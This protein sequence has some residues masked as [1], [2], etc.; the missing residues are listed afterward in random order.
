[1]PRRYNSVPRNCVETL[2]NPIFSQ[3]VPKK[4]YILEIKTQKLNL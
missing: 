4:A 2:K 3:K 1:M